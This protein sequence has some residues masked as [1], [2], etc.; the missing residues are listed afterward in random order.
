MTPPPSY[1]VEHAGR[2]I[3][4][5]IDDLYAPGT[6]VRDLRARLYVN[7]REV[8]AART[9]RPAVLRHDGV[10]VRLRMSL[11]GT[12]AR[13]AELV[14]PEGGVLPLVEVRPAAGTPE[15][16]DS[17]QPVGEQ[18]WRL[19]GRGTPERAKL[20]CGA[21]IVLAVGYSFALNPLRPLLLQTPLAL[22]ALTGS[23]T[24]MVL[25]GASAAVG[26]TDLWWLGLLLATASVVKF[27]PL[28]WWAG[29]LWG[30]R[31]VAFV[32]GRG[33]GSAR[34]SERARRWR[35]PA[36]MASY[37]PGVPGAV[38]YAVAG[39]TGMR[40]RMFLLVD[41]AAAFATRCLWL[42]LG[43]RIGQ[44]VVDVID[45]IA[46]YSL[47]LSLALMAGAILLPALRRRRAD[48]STQRT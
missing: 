41:L 30:D 8:D 39:A 14:L 32:G 13:S 23:N 5:R 40:L 3:E 18:P 9:D 46:G 24:A 42:Y 16:G 31:F 2:R 27:D 37:L 38:V 28:F 48:R 25:L 45:F 21:A 6:R 35:G 33:W 19:P 26:R 44:P 4:V 22:A 7:G 36:V 20:W 11:L 15:P 43:F 34:T 12:R 10:E 29:R 17:T 1:T 47:W